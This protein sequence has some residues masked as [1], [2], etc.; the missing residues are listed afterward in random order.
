MTARRA[1]GCQGVATVTGLSQGVGT[2][3][4]PD[5][6]VHNLV[7]DVG[8][9]PFIKVVYKLCPLVAEESSVFKLDGT[10]HFINA[11]PR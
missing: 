2:K 9:G 8:F 11:S 5:S 6:L 7:D 4:E 1:S 10:F 3:T